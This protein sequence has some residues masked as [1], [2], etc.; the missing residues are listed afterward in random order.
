MIHI[1]FGLDL[2][3]W[4]LQSMEYSNNYQISFYQRL[5]LFP[6]IIDVCKS[7]NNVS[8]SATNISVEQKTIAFIHKKLLF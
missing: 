5:L 8:K 1:L 3:V 4:F 6:G 7:C 2:F